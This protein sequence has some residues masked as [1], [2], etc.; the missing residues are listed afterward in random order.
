MKTSVQT[1][2][3][4]TS[5]DIIKNHDII[6]IESLQITNLMKNKKNAK[7]I[8]DVSW[9][10]FK[11]MLVHKAEWYGKTVVEV[12][13]TFPSSQ[14][15]SSC[16]YKNKDVKGQGLREWKCVCGSY[17]DRDI[18]AGI[19]LKNEANRLLTVGATGIA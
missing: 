4:K 18:N 14:L 10:R 11:T 8:A 2:L 6:G 1:F 7:S 16:G 9:Y 3:H 19:N 17:H 13:K 5:T 15:C 12:S